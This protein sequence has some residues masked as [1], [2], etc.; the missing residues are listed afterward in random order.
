VQHIPGAGHTRHQRVVAALAVP[1][2]SDRALL[3]Q[4]VGLAVGGV[5]IDRQR[6][7]SRASTGLPRAPQG[8]AGDVV[9]LAG[10][11]P[12]ERAQ[13]RAQR[14]R[15]GNPVAQDLAGRTGAQPVGVTDPLAAGQ[16][17]VDQ[18]HS[19]VA[20]VGGPWR[21]AEVDTLIEQLTEHEPL[22]QAGGKDQAGVGDR[23][24]VFEGDGDLVRA[25]G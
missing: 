8:L 15:R 10:R 14:G 3:G 4:P 6:P 17:R 11:A 2:D 16:G 5:D 24:V 7:G 1:V 12:G 18:G 19:L 20:H 22:G 13:E 23:M 21:P 9:E 25:V